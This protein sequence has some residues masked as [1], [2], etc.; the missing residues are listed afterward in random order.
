MG[1]L[2]ERFTN[3]RGISSSNIVA[4]LPFHCLREIFKGFISISVFDGFIRTEFVELIAQCLK[5]VFSA[6][7]QIG[8]FVVTEGG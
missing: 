6:F 8:L 2:T 3:E 7:A 1:K 5:T 4:V